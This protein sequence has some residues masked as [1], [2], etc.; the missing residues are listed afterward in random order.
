MGSDKLNWHDHCSYTEN[1]AP[2]SNVNVTD[3]DESKEIIVHKNLSENNSKD[4][5]ESERNIVNETSLQ[6]NSV[7]VPENTIIEL[8]EEEH[9]EPSVTEKVTIYFKIFECGRNLLDQLDVTYQ[10]AFMATPEYEYYKEMT[11]SLIKANNEGGKLCNEKIRQAVI[12]LREELNG[13][14]K[15]NINKISCD[16]LYQS[17]M[18]KKDVSTIN[19]S[20]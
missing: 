10:R 8:E 13:E 15:G 19:D 4:I 2:S 20:V 14:Y 6:K 9:K 3:K 12:N 1:T 7:D 16:D 11:K 18:N 17:P 5:R